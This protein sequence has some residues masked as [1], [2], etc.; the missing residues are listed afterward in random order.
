MV[1]NTEIHGPSTDSVPALDTGAVSKL[2]RATGAVFEPWFDRANVW[3]DTRMEWLIWLVVFVGFCLRIRLAGESYLNGDETQIMLPP[4]QHG[5]FK[6]YKAAQHF[7]YGPIMNFGLHFMTFFGSSELYFRMPSVIAGSLLIFVGYKWVAETFNKSAGLITG[8]YLAFSPPLITLSAEVR[9]YITHALFV[10]CSLY[11]LE[12]ALRE[13]SSKW[14]RYF[15]I[16]LLLAVLT[17]YMSIWYIIALGVYATLCFLVEE[18][19]RAV[20]LEWLKVQAAVVIVLAVAYVTHLR[21]LRGDAA[22]RLARDGWLRSSY[23]HPEAQTVLNYLREATGNLFGYIFAN[24]RLGEWMILVFLIGI[25]M[26]LLG[27]A[28][29][30]GDRRT[31]ALCLVLPLA[32]TAAAGSIGIY[33]YGGT[34][35]DAFLAV[36]VVACD[37]IAIAA[38]AREKTVVLSLMAVCLIPVWLVTAQPNYLDEPPQVCKISQ[39]RSALDYLSSREPH[40]QVLLADEIGGNTMNYYICHGAVSQWQHI[41]AGLNTYLCAGYRIL[42]VELWGAPPAAFPAALEQAR[43]AMPGQFPDPAWVFYISPVRTN[44]EEISGDRRAVF[45][46]IEIYRIP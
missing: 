17:M 9:H 18:I 28:G 24:D 41:G 29:V 37:S 26:I 20:I 4:L 34:R 33:P 23:F 32:V 14:M 19:P 3:L 35:H 2:K 30:R 39:M 43:R 36:F 5:L 27:K 13:T 10:A 11:C 44:D 16:A 1:E 25:G 22:E 6:V 7:P 45:G 38:L 15:G 31:P 46:K 42:T 40:P 8:L 21:K 12:R